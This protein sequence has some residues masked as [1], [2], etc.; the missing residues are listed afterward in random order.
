M[1]SDPELSV[2]RPIARPP[3]LPSSRSRAFRSRAR[4]AILVLA[5]ATAILTL[6]AAAW[7]PKSAPGLGYT[8]RV[9]SRPKG[10]GGGGRQAREMSMGPGNW[11]WTGSVVAS[12]GRGRVDITDGGAEGLFGQGD[13]MLFDASDFLIVRPSSKEYIGLPSAGLSGGLEML[14]TMPNVR[15]EVSDLKVE[16]ARVGA[17]DT[18][19]GQTTQH[20]RLTSGYIVSIDAGFLQQAMAIEST[21]DYWVANVEGLTTGPFLK[22][23][24]GVM[25]LGGIVKEVGPKVDSAVARMGNVSPL[26]AVT[27]TSITDGRGGISETEATILVSAIKRRDVD[28][29]VFVLADDFQPA[30]IGGLAQ[31]F[32]GA[33]KGDPGAKWRA[34]PR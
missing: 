31:L 22:V 8:I 11:N 33:A 2:S 6:V 20:Y 27:E 12:G 34:K 1:I 21:T 26:K 28:P 3:V 18:V 10:G 14:R 13:Y 5:S 23:F 30:N 7:P 16:M 17:G 4:N 32:G 29:G 15:V 9:S 19:A 24:S 25:S